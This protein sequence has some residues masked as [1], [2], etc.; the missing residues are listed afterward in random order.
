M[1]LSLL[2]SYFKEFPGILGSI[3]NMYWTNQY[4]QKE[5]WFEGLSLCYLYYCQHLTNMFSKIVSST[6]KINLIWDVWLCI[7]TYGRG[8]WMWWVSRFCNIALPKVKENYTICQIHTYTNDF[9]MFVCITVC[10]L[11]VAV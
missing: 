4:H 11:Q 6:I 2:S 1:L 7:L 5:L 3:T 10:W 9:S 8:W